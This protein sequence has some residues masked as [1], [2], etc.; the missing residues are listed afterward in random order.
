VRIVAVHSDAVVVTSRLWQTTATAVRAGEEAM[1]IDSPYFPDELEVLP[2]VLEQSGF[3]VDALLATHGDW[4]H[5]LGRLAYPGMSLGV[6]ESTALRLRDDP[7]VAQLELRKA[8]DEHYV[9]RE[10]PLALGAWQSLPVPG[11][12]ELG[13]EE[14]ELHPAEGHTSDGMAIFARHAGVLVCGDYLSDVEIPAVADLALYRGTLERLRPLVEDADV[15]VPGHGSPQK[16]DEALKTLEEDLV[17]LDGLEAG[18]A[19]LPKERDTPVQRRAHAKN[20]ALV[21][22][23]Q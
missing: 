7:G 12:L 14:L 22:N 9:A 1:L 20:L 5:L 3:A 10:R 21:T 13:G 8:D 4:D 11:K 18:E 15:V 19:R 16:H 2:Q 17:Y 23:R 6:A